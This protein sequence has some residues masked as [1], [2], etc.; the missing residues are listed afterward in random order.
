MIE[1]NEL[2][3]YF[4]GELQPH[5]PKTPLTKHD[6]A[7]STLAYLNAY[8][9]TTFMLQDLAGDAADLEEEARLS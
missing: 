8:R 2:I 3:A 7:M 1:L 6:V 9:V 5:P 4:C